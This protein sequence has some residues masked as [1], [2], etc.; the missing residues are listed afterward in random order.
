MLYWFV[1][2]TGV[3]RPGP[4]LDV[5]PSFLAVSPGGRWLAF[6]VGGAVGHTIW[7]KAIAGDA[8]AERVGEIATGQT[9]RELAIGDD[10]RVL[11][12]P[13]SWAGDLYA[14][15]APAGTRF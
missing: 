12:T 11:A 8:P 15:P 1:P 4:Q 14:V 13:T 7:R 2:S 9:M 5:T 3:E 10:G 6:A